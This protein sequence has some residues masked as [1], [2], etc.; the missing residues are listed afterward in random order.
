MAARAKAKQ[1]KSSS[2]GARRTASTTA[3]KPTAAALLRER[4]ALIR[5]LKAAE[6]RISELEE[7]NKEAVNRIDWVID[8]L[9]SVMAENR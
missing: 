9:Q 6:H 2:S 5:Q 3:K 7:I 4:D 8:S 1:S